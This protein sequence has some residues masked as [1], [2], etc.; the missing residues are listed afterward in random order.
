MLFHNNLSIN[1]ITVDEK[2]K[3]YGKIAIRV[4]CICLYNELDLLQSNS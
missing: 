1:D 3:L 4:I 2:I